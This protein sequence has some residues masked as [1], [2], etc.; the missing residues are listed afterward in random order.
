[1]ARKSRKPAGS[2][3]EAVDRD[4]VAHWRRLV[5]E[6]LASGLSQD[7]FCEQRR[8]SPGQFRYWKYTKLALVGQGPEQDAAPA[9]ASLLPVRVVQGP[10]SWGAHPEE[11]GPSG[12]E[13]LLPG[14]LRVSLRR[15]FDG[16]VLREV[17]EVLGC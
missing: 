12:V 2:P 8:V 9:A 16:S 5:T 3:A 13:V 7:E 14:G 10:R 15:G 11:D 4:E 1:M 6:Q 17:V